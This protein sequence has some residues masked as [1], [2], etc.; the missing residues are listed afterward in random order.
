MHFED[1]SVNGQHV[2]PL[3]RSGLSEEAEGSIADGGHFGRG[4][5][6]DFQMR[7]IAAARN[8]H[9]LWLQVK[10]IAC[11]DKSNGDNLSAIGKEE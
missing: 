10:M 7:R 2:G 8:G 5:W 11:V 4:E 6:L 1:V 3:F 9:V